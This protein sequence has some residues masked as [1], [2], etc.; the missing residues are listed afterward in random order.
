MK[1]LKD[2]IEEKK[3]QGTEKNKY[4]SREFQDYG[5]RLA[6]ELGDLEHKNIYMRLAKTVDRAVLEQCRRFVIDSN[7]DKKGALFMW[8]M[9]ELKR[10]RTTETAWMFDADGVLTDLESRVVTEK[11]IPEELVRRA[12][13][14][15][16][17]GIITG[18]AGIFVLENIISEIKKVEWSAGVWRNMIIVAEK[19][20]VMVTFDNLG[21]PVKKK[22]QILPEGFGDFVSKLESEIQEYGDLMFV[23]LKKETMATVEM[24][25]GANWKEFKMKRG[26]IAERIRILLR[27]YTWGEAYRIDE[28]AIS[29]DV[30]NMAMGKKKAGE[31]F[32]KELMNRR[33]SPKMFVCFGDSRSDLDMLEGILGKNKI[34]VFVGEVEQI[35]DRKEDVVM[36]WVGQ[37]SRGTA[38]ALR[39]RFV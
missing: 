7:A 24:V 14:G 15:E 22:I 4:I 27:D 13:R 29:I 30:E 23:D 5:Y 26:E 28:T 3:L 8:K 21:Q 31:V 11:S 10:G 20:G 34:F 18:R 39:R 16:P 32:A 36:D 9:K 19:G 1:S 35:A 25:K 17:V 12:L 38:E 6:A 2:L 33:I 37:Y